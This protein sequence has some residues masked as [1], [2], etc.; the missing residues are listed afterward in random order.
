MGCSTCKHLKQ[1]LEFRTGEYSKARSSAFY[2]VSTKLA[3]RKNVDMERARNDWE[4]HQLVCP[5]AAEIRQ[6]ET[7]HAAA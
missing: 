3:A 4:E 1:V 5:Y 7:D 6:A 2:L